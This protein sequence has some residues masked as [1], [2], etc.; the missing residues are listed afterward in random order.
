MSRYSTQIINGNRRVDLVKGKEPTTELALEARALWDSDHDTGIQVEKTPDDDTIRFDLGGTTPIVD[1]VLFNQVNGFHFNTALDDLDFKVSGDT[2]DNAIFF[3]ASAG[4]ETLYL[5][6]S[7]QIT[8]TGGTP[9]EI[10]LLARRDDSDASI[11]IGSLAHSNTAGRGG[12]VFGGRSRGTESSPLVVQPDD[13]LFDFSAV[14]F[15]GA[16]YAVGATIRFEVDTGTISATSMPGRLSFRT[17]P[18]GTISSTEKM[19]IGESGIVINEDSAAHTYRIETLGDEYAFYNDGSIDTWSMGGPNTSLTINSLTVKPKLMVDRAGGD[20]NIN[21]IALSNLDSA[22]AGPF[23]V[24]ARARGAAVSASTFQ[25]VQNGDRLGVFR[26]DAHDGT[27]FLTVGDFSFQAD[28]TV[29]TGIIP[30][31]FVLRLTDTTGTLFTAY[32]IA[33]TGRLFFNPTGGADITLFEDGGIRANQNGNSAATA[34]FIYQTANYSN[35]VRIDVSEDQ[36]NVASSA[37]SQG[38]LLSADVDED[39]VR[40]NRSNT[41]CNLRIESSS[42]GVD[43]WESDTTND[44]IIENG[45]KIVKTTRVTTTYTALASDHTILCDTDG[46]AFTLTLPAGIDGTYYRII[47]VGTSGNDVTIATNAS[48]TILGNASGTLIDGDRL[49]ITYETTEG[50]W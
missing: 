31:E 8:F 13:N 39:E 22:S 14:G 50:W 48:E 37:N 40:I 6:G 33:S 44:K 35:G 32:N 42:A 15:D 45:G 30:T 26:S 49:I 3:D 24:W 17:S 27:E 36:F 28:N 19:R 18:D 20:S 1:A 34:D 5:N 4:V 16:N 29:S 7:E 43:L 21:F 10:K 46:G 47:N 23:M 41:S 2:T 38:G 11:G 9:L 25:A 12:I